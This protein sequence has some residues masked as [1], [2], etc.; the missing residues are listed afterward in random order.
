MKTAGLIG[1]LGPESTIE[2][3]RRLIAS[4]RA[5]AGEDH[6]PALVITS[7]DL[8]KI[9][10]LVQADRR[11]ELVEELAAEL[12]RL[13]RAGADF[14]ALTANTPHLVF[15]A[16][17][18]V[19]PLPLISIVEA[20]ARAAAGRGMTRLAL[21]GT[22]FTLQ[23]RFYPEVFEPLGIALVIPSPEERDF[24]HHIYMGELL[25]GVVTPQTRAGLVAIA[26]RIQT[27][28]RIEGVILGGTELSLILGP[29]DLPGLALL[30]TT[31]IH[32]EE[33]VS[34]MLA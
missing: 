1:G 5:R 32:V 18:R 20:T 25:K 34:A 14:A 4:Y 19:S 29:E 23:A 33:I 15:D 13:A 27:R 3:Y 12:G 30:D 31:Q 22:A 2:Y 11:A 24:L 17:R 16:L 10:A 8:P 9:V 21:F 26:R 7:A 6:A 28:D